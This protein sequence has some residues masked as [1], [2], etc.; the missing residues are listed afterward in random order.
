MPPCKGEMQTTNDLG[1]SV[2][3]EHTGHAIDNGTKQ[4]K[5]MQQWE[6]IT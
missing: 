6:Y 3:E 5:D 1:R 4:E 2:L